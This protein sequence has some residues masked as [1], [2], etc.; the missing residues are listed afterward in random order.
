MVNK[1][2]LPNNGTTNDVGGII[3]ASR[4]KNTVNDKRTEIL[5]VT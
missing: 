2:N 5:R 4:R 1:T 3:S